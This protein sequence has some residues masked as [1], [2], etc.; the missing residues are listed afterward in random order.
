MKRALTL[1]VI[2]KQ[3]SVCFGTKC[4]ATAEAGRV[5]L[6]GE[7]RPDR[8]HLRVLPTVLSFGRGACQGARHP[9]EN[10]ASLQRLDEAASPR[11]G[12][13]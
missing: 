13:V 12:P 8:L 6:P 10:S 9:A 7:S 4:H 1:S 5:A 11:E 3:L 2:L